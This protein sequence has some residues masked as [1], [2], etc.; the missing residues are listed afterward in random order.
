MYICTVPSVS[1]VCNAQTTTLVLVVVRT[2]AVC[3]LKF[4][5][6][7]SLCDRW[8]EHSHLFHCLCRL[9]HSRGT[10]SCLSA[11][12]LHC[13]CQRLQREPELWLWRWPGCSGWGLVCGCHVPGRE[14]GVEQKKGWN[15]AKEVG[16]TLLISI[17]QFW[18]LC[19]FYHP[20]CVYSDSIII[21]YLLH[22]NPPCTYNNPPVYVYCY[23]QCA[24]TV[25]SIGS[26]WWQHFMYHSYDYSDRH[27]LFI[28]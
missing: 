3:S 4:H 1:S 20:P 8:C 21:D 15:Q 23:S 22:N 19:V 14:E 25:V 10:G 2:W 27:Y 11:P 12:C 26:L 18:I 28:F 24:Y 17:V 9:L 16:K 7:M 13:R 5:F 6:L